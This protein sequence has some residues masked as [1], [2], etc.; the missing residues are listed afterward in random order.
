MAPNRCRSE[1]RL[2]SSHVTEIRKL[3]PYLRPFFPLLT[4]ALILLVVT[5][6]LETVPV[7]MLSPILDGWSSD[8][9]QASGDAEGKFAFLH[10]WLNL[11]ED[12]LLKI[13]FVLVVVAFLKGLCLYG[14]EYAMGYIGHRVIA[15]L[16]NHL[17]DHLLEQSLAFFSHNSSGR[18]MVRVIS[19]TELLQIAVSRILTDFLRQVFLFLCFLG[20]VIYTDWKLALFSFLAAPLVLFV[21][22]N[23]GRRVRVASRWSQEHLEEM[24]HTLQEAIAGNQI[25]KAFTMEDYEKRRFG[26]LNQ[27]LVR[28][29]LR[30]ARIGALNTPLVEFIGYLSF[31]PFLL[32]AHHQINQGFTIGIFAVFMVSLFRLY[33]PVRKLSRM[34]LHF[35]HSSAG[36]ERIFDLLETRMETPDLPEAGTLPTLSREIVFDDVSFR[37]DNG[38]DRA[39]LQDLELSISRGEVVALV[40]PSGAGKSSM[41]SLIPRFF[42]VTSGRITI[43]GVDIRQVRLQSLRDQIAIVTQDTFLFNDTVMKNIGYGRGDCSREEIEEAARAAYIHD[44]IVALP[45]GYDTIIGDRGQQ[46]SGGQ[47]QRVAIARAILKQAPILILDEATS[48]LDTESEQLVQRALQN[49]ME[50]RTTLVIAHR[51][52]TVREADRIVLLDA[53]RIVDIGNHQGLLNRSLLYRRLSD[54]EIQ[55]G[56]G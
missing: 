17:Y 13:A 56:T 8:S 20:L 9:L 25:I 7:T 45:R 18:L 40:G 38:N 47:R 30:A 11:Q 46:L 39:V 6:V 23:L 48:A 16:R 19:D 28:V 37:Y 4:L 26:E 43:D 35:Q 33:E 41:A 27:N 51:L 29:N 10:E 3:L 14:A 53:G 49:L 50:N 1:F 21:V 44:V 31:F 32:Y 5:G 36:A 55:S 54:V 34:H 24:S 52:S 12:P 2:E 15:S 42:D 22:L